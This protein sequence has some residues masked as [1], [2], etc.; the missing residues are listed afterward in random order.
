M[1]G[2]QTCLFRSPKEGE[3]DDELAKSLGLEPRRLPPLVGMTPEEELELANAAKEERDFK[4]KTVE[5][6]V[7]AVQGEMVGTTLQYLGTELVRLR[8]ERKIQAMSM[9]AER[10]RRMREAVEAGIA[11]EAAVAPRPG[12]RPVRKPARAP[13][14]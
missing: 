8:E 6:S 10:T 11:P 13:R 7:A 5:L 12:Q 1:T 3:A 4:A 14:P 2:V 9:L